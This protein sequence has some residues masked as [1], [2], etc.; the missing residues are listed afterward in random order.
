[1]AGC[2]VVK[3]PAKVRASVGIPPEQLGSIMHASN[4]IPGFHGQ[5]YNLISNLRRQLTITPGWLIDPGPVES[6]NILKD[7]KKL[8]LAYFCNNPP[9]LLTSNAGDG[10]KLHPVRTQW[11][12]DPAVYSDLPH[13]LAEAEFIDQIAIIRQGKIIA[14]GSK[15]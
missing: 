13:N 5:A 7:E 11:D 12:G 15:H 3:E 4:G 6:Q 1:V 2:D 10:P 8:A 9:V 14:S